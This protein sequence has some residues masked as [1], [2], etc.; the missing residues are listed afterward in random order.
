M[1]RKV[2]LGD[3]IYVT[4]KIAAATG[5]SQAGAEQR[6]QD[7]V[8]PAARRG[9][10]VTLSPGQS[11]GTA[12]GASILFTTN[13]G[14]LSNGTTSGSKVVAVTNSSGVAS[15]TLSLPSTAQTVQVQ[16]Q[17]PYGIGGTIASFSETAQ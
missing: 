6:G 15:V 16:A 3:R 8:Q 7:S 1:V 13:A 11:G 17:A 4:R 12:T 5:L 9:I 14:T 10:A 2:S